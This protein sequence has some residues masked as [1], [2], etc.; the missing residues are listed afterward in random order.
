M[1][2]TITQPSTK[3]TTL[4]DALHRP[5]RDLRISV[6]DRCNFRCRYCMPEEEYK[7]HYKFLE[8]K[9]WLTFEEIFRLTK[10]FVKLGVT[11]VR[12]TGGEPLLRDG[13]PALIRKLTGLSG[14]EDLALTTN[15]SLLAQKARRLKE[16]GLRR[17]TVSL[18]TLDQNVFRAMSGNRGSVDRVLE[19][20]REAQGLGFQAI[21]I[22]VVV[23]KGVNDHRVLDLVRYF[24]GTGCVLR[25]IEYMDVGNCNHWRSESVVPSKEL[26]QKIQEHFPLKPLEANYEG[27]VASR[28]QFVDGSGE[29]GFISSVTQPF[30]GTCHRARLSTDGKIYTCLF[31]SQGT[32]LRNP[33]REGASDK[34]LLNL[35]TGVWQKRTDRYSELRSQFLASH[36]T[37]HKVEMFQIGG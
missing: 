13:L 17:L 21:K 36:Q 25:F 11:K 12:L 16:A 6:I 7:D 15:G 22:N 30:C 4:H 32:D 8:K 35:I 10:L 26:I 14:I 3:S 9:N 28:Y 23:Q 19:S 31:A 18:D 1:S 29:I 5:L 34:E 33:L 27:E 24:R 2:T 37:T 20:I